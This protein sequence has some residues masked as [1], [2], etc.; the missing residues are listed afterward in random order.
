MSSSIVLLVRDLRVVTHPHGPR[1]TREV[2]ASEIRRRVVSRCDRV[3]S[4]LQRPFS[5]GSL[6][7]RII[8]LR[9]HLFPIPSF[10]L[11]LTLSVYY[12]FS[13]LLL[14]VF[15]LSVCECVPKAIKSLPTV[16]RHRSDRLSDRHE[17][18]FIYQQNYPCTIAVIDAS[19]SANKDRCD[20]FHVHLVDLN[21]WFAGGFCMFVE[22]A[23][24]ARA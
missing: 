15:S 7:L 3:L 14:S 12:A 10:P 16:R 17:S 6:G 8:F 2:P 20:D 24:Y 4:P 21:D 22:V 13:S 9:A 18:I 19:I 5:R 23:G 11:S 1:D